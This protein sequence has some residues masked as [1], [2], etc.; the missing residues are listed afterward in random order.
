MCDR[1]EGPGL[2][3]LRLAEKERQS[4]ESEAASR[5][6]P[7]RSPDRRR[8]CG[9]CEASQDVRLLNRAQRD[10]TEV[11]APKYLLRDRKG[12]DQDALRWPCFAGA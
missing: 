7:R 12:V 4:V 11:L 10:W 5:C 1:R 9:V 2:G 3:R 8:E 6:R